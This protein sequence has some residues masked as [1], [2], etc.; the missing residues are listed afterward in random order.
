MKT[1]TKVK[2][3]RGLVA[4]MKHN[5]PYEY[6]GKHKVSRGS[7][8]ELG[9]APHDNYYCDK[10]VV[11]ILGHGANVIIPKDRINLYLST[12]KVTTRTRFK[13]IKTL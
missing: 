4:V 3:Y 2:E 5:F 9:D 13:K 8:I 7:R 10:G 11:L 1:K 6:Y 12:T